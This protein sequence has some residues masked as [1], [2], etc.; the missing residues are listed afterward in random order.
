VCWYSSTLGE[1]A[2]FSS[3]LSVLHAV[4]YEYSLTQFPS[5]HTYV[6]PPLILRGVMKKGL[7]AL[8]AMTGFFIVSCSTTTDPVQSDTQS[9]DVGSTQG[10]EV[11][12]D[13]WEQ[14]ISFWDDCSGQQLEGTVKVKGY[15]QH[16]ENA[17]GSF[18]MR[19]TYNVS[20]VLYDAD[21]NKYVWK[22][23]ITYN[24]E[25]ESE[26]CP[27]TGSATGK[28]RLMT[29]GGKNNP[30]VTFDYAYS[31]DCDWNFEMEYDNWASTCK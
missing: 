26:G 28:L 10:T 24:D 3:C 27:G 8:L 16:K 20:G 6:R 19:F 5:E 9:K 1:Q 4:N 15:M 14:P 31:Y 11:M 17:D 22:D 29:S 13:V 2:L 25:W 30:E 23:N 21:G 7:L 18:S 12:H